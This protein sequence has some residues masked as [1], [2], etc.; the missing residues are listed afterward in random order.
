MQYAIPAD[1]RPQLVDWEAGTHIDGTATA[2]VWWL[3][4]RLHHGG[5]DALVVISTKGEMTVFHDREQVGTSA[6]PSLPH[7]P[8]GDEFWPLASYPQPDWH[9]PATLSHR[10]RD[11][12]WMVCAVDDQLGLAASI[13]SDG[14]SRMLWRLGFACTLLGFF[15]PLGIGFE[16]AASEFRRGV[17]T[18]GERD[19]RRVKRSLIE[20][21]NHER[22]AMRD[23]SD[24]IEAN[25]RL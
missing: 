14:E 9:D 20:R 5:R 7:A 16:G 2:A 25:W 19:A 11:T 6:A 23:L 24:K 1:D 4:T 21:L 22:K 10:L 3:P 15:P 18:L 12:G 8:A 13:P 17:E